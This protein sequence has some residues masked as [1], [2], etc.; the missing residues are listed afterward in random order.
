MRLWPV[1]WMV[2]FIV[3]KNSQLLW[4]RCF[5]NYWWVFNDLP[6]QKVLIFVKYPFVFW[7]LCVS[8]AHHFD[9]N[10]VDPQW[11]TLEHFF[12]C[13]NC[14]KNHIWSSNWGCLSGAP[15]LWR[16]LGRNFLESYFEKDCN[17]IQLFKAWCPSG[18]VEN[19]TKFGHATFLV[20]SF[21]SII[22][23]KFKFKE[24]R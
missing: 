6:K 11:F 16:R 10:T 20:W 19:H 5:W 15:L 7:G 2:H 13:G 3:D 18:L 22:A 9:N 4:W 8:H 14:L 17:A 23:I 24:K 1:R 21:W 12:S